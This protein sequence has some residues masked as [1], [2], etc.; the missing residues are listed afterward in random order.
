MKYIWLF[1]V[2]VRSQRILGLFCIYIY[3]FYTEKIT[4]PKMYILFIIQV[5]VLKPKFSLTS[6]SPLK[7]YQHLFA[8]KHGPLFTDNSPL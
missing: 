7:P 4:T 1:S 3:N 2:P 5:T 6:S 8:S